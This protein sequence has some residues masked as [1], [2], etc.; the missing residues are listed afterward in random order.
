MDDLKVTATGPTS[1]TAISG[2][3][4]EARP[5]MFLCKSCGTFMY[6]GDT[7]A[8][9]RHSVDKN[10]VYLED[11]PAKTPITKSF[12]FCTDDTYPP[13][14]LGHTLLTITGDGGALLVAMYPDGRLVF[15]E[16]YKPDHAAKVFWDALATAGYMRGKE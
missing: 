1:I 2:L 16:T 7:C 12:A 4:A 5:P 3:G 6:P 9:G 10:V 14:G 15:G 11:A 13:F 8:C